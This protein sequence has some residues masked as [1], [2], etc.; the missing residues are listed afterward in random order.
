VTRRTLPQQV[1]DFE[2]LVRTHA[3]ELIGSEDT[4]RSVLALT[5]LPFT[6]GHLPVQRI[7]EFGALKPGISPRRCTCIRSVGS[8]WGTVRLLVGNEW[9]AAIRQRVDGTE[10]TLW[11]SALHEAIATAITD[12]L[13]AKQVVAKVEASTVEVTFVHD[14]RAGTARQKRRVE[15]PAWSAI[16]RNYAGNAQSRIDLLMAM[17]PETLPAGRLLLIHGPAGTGKSTLLRALGAA[18]SSWCTLDVLLDPDRFLSQSAYL[19]DVAFNGRPAEDTRW[20]LIVAE[21]CDEYFRAGA[22]AANG[23]NLAR[24]LNVT[25]GI[26]SQSAKLIVCLTAA[27]PLNT[28]HPS[29]RRAGRCIADISV[30][31]LTKDEAKAWLGAKPVPPSEQPD[32]S[33]SIAE[34]FASIGRPSLVAFEEPYVSGIYL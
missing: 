7:V 26:L 31:R 33:L 28:I 10:T 24:L 14:G 18:W 5:A 4:F 30:P 23:Q 21:D 17:T 34:L 32:D 3:T 22:K 20:R 11:I 25:D 9:V 13:R 16:R 1:N 27:E 19:N 29:M 12:E 8:A 2:E 6:L 15:A